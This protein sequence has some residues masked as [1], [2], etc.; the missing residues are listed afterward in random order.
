MD[1]YLIAS[2]INS[3]LTLLN[4][5]SFFSFSQ[6]L[7]QLSSIL[8]NARYDL[9]FFLL[10]VAITLAGYS[11]AGFALYGANL[12]L[13]SDFLASFFTCLKMLNGVFHYREM[14]EVDPDVSALFFGSFMLIVNV[15]FLNMM[16]AI[17]VAHYNE[18]M[19]EL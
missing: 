13:F 2:S 8:N 1:Y 10:M 5:L 6:K 17:I 12:E 3:F 18:F 14:Y 9:F 4:I 11:I 7:S 16:I 15:A 19:K